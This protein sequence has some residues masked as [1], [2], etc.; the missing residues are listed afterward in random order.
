M[1]GWIGRN[2]RVEFRSLKVP[3]VIVFPGIPVAIATETSRATD[4]APDFPKQEPQRGTRSTSAPRSGTLSTAIRCALTRSIHVKANTVSARKR[5]TRKATEWP[6]CLDIS[7][8]R[9]LD[10]SK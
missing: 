4:L 2:A 7:V 10:R 1:H 9:A 5:A 3:L 8:A 6:R